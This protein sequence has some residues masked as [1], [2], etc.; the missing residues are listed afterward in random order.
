MQQKMQMELYN[1]LAILSKKINKQ[2]RPDKLNKEIYKND[3]KVKLFIKPD[4]TGK[5]KIGT[6]KI[7]SFN[8]QEELEAKLKKTII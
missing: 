1:I 8:N 4:G 3:I 2:L 6:V 7:F 5:L